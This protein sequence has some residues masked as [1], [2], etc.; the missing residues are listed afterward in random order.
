MG[1]LWGK[2]PSAYV[3]AICLVLPLLAAEVWTGFWIGTSDPTLSAIATSE[4]A[5]SLR[6][7][8]GEWAMLLA[9][10]WFALAYW[11]RNVRLWEIAL[12]V[13][14]GAAALVRTGNE[15]LDA[16]ALILP[17]GR[18]ISLARPPTWLLG[19]AAAVGL[20]VGMGTAYITRLPAL[21]PAAIEAASRAQGKGA[22]FVDWRWAATVQSRL[23]GRKVLASGGLASESADFWLDYVRIVQDY[24]QW[25]SEL[26]DL[27]VTEVVLNTDQPELADQVRASADWRVLYDTGNALVAE[28]VNT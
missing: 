9:L 22:V 11:R 1:R 25:P 26:R 16:L 17:L 18:Q 13:I 3:A 15:W 2:S 14:G 4:Q 7:P 5:L 21:P 27:G 24:Y 23:N 19:A 20:A 8:G 28:R 12:I 10:V 6:S